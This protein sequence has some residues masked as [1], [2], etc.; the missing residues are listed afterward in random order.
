LQGKLVGEAK[1]HLSTI[2]EVL[3]ERLARLACRWGV[4]RPSAVRRLNRWRHALACELRGEEKSGRR[5]SR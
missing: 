1:A 4:T 5:I 3:I 2:I